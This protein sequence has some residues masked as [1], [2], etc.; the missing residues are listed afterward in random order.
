MA[1]QTF[2]NPTGRT[3][4]APFL[5]LP[6]VHGPLRTRGTLTHCMPAARAEAMPAS[7]SSNTRQSAGATPSL[8]AAVRKGSGFGLA[9]RVVFS[10]DEHGKQIEE[11]ETREGVDD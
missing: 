11:P 8:L 10:A 9:P 4:P 6:A 5:M 1:F 3:L 2:F 7:A